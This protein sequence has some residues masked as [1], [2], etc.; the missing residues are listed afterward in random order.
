MNADGFSLSVVENAVLDICVMLDE[1]KRTPPSWS[2]YSED[3]LWRELLFCILGSRVRFETVCSAVERLDDVGLLTFSRRMSDLDRYEMDANEALLGVYPFYKLR[4][5]QIRRAAEVLYHS[6]DSI[7]DFLNDAGDFRKARQRLV[8]E[9]SG[10]GP[11]QSSLF[12]RN[13]GYADCIAVLDVHVLTYMKW[14]GLTEALVKSVPTVCKYERLENLFT[15]YARSFECSVNQFDFA[16]WIVMRV[17]K[18]EYKTW[19]L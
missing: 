19:E 4:S 9:V 12:L 11:K 7:K 2:G 5:G 1:T 3:E 14:V 18:R 8:L 10:L 15:E 16:V 17:I 13:I 6:W